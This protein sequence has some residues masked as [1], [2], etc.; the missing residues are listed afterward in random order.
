MPH[1][2]P[3][4][5]C[6]CVMGLLALGG[7]ETLGEPARGP[8]RV[9]PENPRYFTDGSGK[10]IY[11]TG[12]HTWNSLQDMGLTDPPGTFDWEAYLDFLQR[13]HHNFIRLWRWELVRWDTAPNGGPGVL[14]VAPHPWARTGPGK[15]ADGKPKFNLKRFEEDYFQRLRARVV[16]AHERGIYVSIMLFEGWGLQFVPEGWE[17][18]PFHPEN[19]VNGIDG[20]ANGDGQ[21]LEVHTL[22]HPGVTVLQEAYVRRVEA[23]VNDLDNV[24]Y[25]ISNEN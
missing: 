23:T 6:T 7:S 14:T 16:A 1:F 12:S 17:A 13:Y 3:N 10:A 8:L 18:H 24:L 5:L 9:H 20:D 15:A 25:E 21:G 11:L 4:H 22:T 2:V 19:N